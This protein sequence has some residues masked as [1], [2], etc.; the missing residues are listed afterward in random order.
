MKQ[1]WR[2]LRRDWIFSTVAIAILAIGVAA[3]TSVFTLI[4]TILFK[5]LPY[6]EPAGLVHL[7]ESLPDLIAGEYPF[8]APDVG[9]LRNRSKSFVELAAS[10]SQEMDLSGS[11]EPTRV[12]GA[13]LEA[14]AWKMLGVAPLLGRLFDEGED[15]RGDRVLVLS[16]A[17]WQRYFNGDPTVIGRGVDVDRRAYTIQ[18]VMP[19]GFVFPPPGMESRDKRVDLWLP[20]SFTK[21][22][23]ASLGDNYNNLVLARLKPGLTSK[24]LQDDLARVG[25]EIKATYPAGFPGGPLKIASTPLMEEVVGDLRGLFWLLISSVGAVLLI[26][27][28]NIASLLLV[29][30]V[31]RRDEF[32]VRKALG[33]TSWHLL[34]ASLAEALLIAIPGG[35]LG[36]LSSVWALELLIRLAPRSLPRLEELSI[37]WRVAVFTLAVSLLA[38]L[39]FSL[40]PAWQASRTDPGALRNGDKGGTQS[41]GALRLGHALVSLEVAL[42]I[43]LLGATGLLIETYRNLLQTNPGFQA[44]RLLAFQ[45][46]PQAAAYGND[47][48]QHVAFF[49]RLDSKLSAL[50]GLKSFSYADGA[51]LSSGWQRIFMLESQKEIS[52]RAPQMTNHILAS[53]GHFENLG[54]RVLS[55]RSFNWSDREGQAPVCLINQTLSKL[56]FPNG[57]A[58]GK[59]L[60][61]G[62][63]AG[64]AP[65]STI[66][67]IVADTKRNELN[68]KP[69][70]QT[71]EPILQN[72]ARSRT[73]F[74]RTQQQPESLAG[75][76]R[77]IVRSLDPR[78]VV[79]EMQSMEEVIEDKAASK[80][81]QM[82]LL[83][84]FGAAALLLAVTGIFGVIANMVTRQTREIG[85]RMALGASPVQIL[86]MILRCGLTPVML[87]VV[88]GL[89][90]LI[91]IGKS[92]ESFLYGVK[93][94]DP[95]TLGVA[96]GVLL[97]SAIAAML[98]PARRAV[99]VSPSVA[100]RGE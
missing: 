68:E 49:A 91:A 72:Q 48:G 46:A 21:S 65:L 53:P 96:T 94:G 41:R 80:K 40:A 12:N 36:L 14:Q 57:D 93:P 31:A 55:G 27:C 1:A 24:Q 62:G 26:G 66:I 9:E 13:H 4:N 39:F 92:L 88:I 38:A 89:Y 3:N 73:Y 79:A 67:G 16:Y 32:A 5:P 11:I 58:V 69:M 87:G 45:I 61:I 86:A 22:D 30:T 50:P 78:Q 23:L 97:I 75:P 54:I 19:N 8:S 10:S 56:F 33:A 85:I 35:A 43:M 37:D 60:K 81:F 90:G 100:I 84:V 71:Y 99:L 44:G 95:I 7:E 98:I 20:M 82:L 42:C 83:S 63:P 70:P 74:L 59:R 47:T 77:E 29:R 76:V 52:S 34:R 25:N 51:P 17:A 18:A 15:R 28:A 64:D 2:N 6:R